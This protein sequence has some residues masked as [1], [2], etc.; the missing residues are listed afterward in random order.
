ME[1]PE[2]EIIRGR[3]ESK[4]CD[5]CGEED[6]LISLGK[7]VHQWLTSKGPFEFEHNDVICGSCG[8]V[9]SREVPD[10]EFLREYYKFTYAECLANFDIESRLEII[11][12]FIE[13]GGSILELGSNAGEFSEALG[14]GG[15][16]ITCYD[17]MSDDQGLPDDEKFDMVAGY[18]IL[19]HIPYPRKWL[20]RARKYVKPNGY[21]LLETPNYATN[22]GPSMF[23]EHF[24]HFSIDHMRMLLESMGF[25]VLHTEAGRR[26]RYFGFVTVAR[27]I[28]DDRIQRFTEGYNNRSHIY[29]FRNRL[30]KRLTKR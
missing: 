9:F 1:I 25:E 29:P 17:L 10:E 8:F 23:P 20:R 14:K 15:F 27:Y 28:I 19:E 2:E 30:K 7:R 12:R 13:P 4:P 26:S 6:H 3:W 11:G 21:L 22:S 18:Y 24:V 5:I 16:K